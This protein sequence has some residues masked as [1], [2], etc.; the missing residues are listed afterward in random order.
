MIDTS[1]LAVTYAGATEPALRCPALTIDEGE[2][3]LLAG[4]TGSGKST[5]LRTLNGLVPHFS[6][7]TLAGR[8]IVAGRDTRTHRPRDLAEVVGFVGQDPQAGFVTETVEEEIAFGMETLGVGEQAMRRRVEE[9]LDVL[10]LAPLRTRPLR[11]LSGGQQQRVSVAAVLAAGPRILVLDEPTSAL[12]PVSAEEVL[13]SL[14]RLVHDL[15][16]TVVLAEHRLERTVHHADRVIL[17]DDGVA[18]GLLSPGEA[19]SRASNVPPVVELGRHRGW[20]PLP[21]SVRDARRRA[22]GLRRDL[23]QPAARPRSAG[24]AAVTTRSLHVRRSGRTVL[25]ELD[26][27]VCAGAVTALMGRN[28]SGKSTLLGAICAMVRVTSGTIEAAGIRPDRCR[29]KDLIGLI[30]MVPQDAGSLLLADSVEGECRTAD[31][32]FGRPPGSCRRI[33]DRLAGLD[34]GRH[35]RDLSEGQRVLLAVA[36]I[37]TGDPA[38]LLLDEPTRGLD[39]GAKRRLAA[40]LRERTANGGSVLMA[41]HDVEMAAEVADDV[42]LIAD[43]DV[44]AEGAAREILCDSMAFAPQIAKVMH[45]RTFLTVDDVLRAAGGDATAPH[46][47]DPIPAHPAGEAPR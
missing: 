12:D 15:G 31:R 8:V 18:S 29:P 19:M 25:R 16:V 4:A 30:G 14:D 7:G 5:L 37:L 42:L 21:L 13:A 33:L 44:I 23:P 43:G 26:L 32:D 24:E 20:E 3:V 27:T 46:A 35:P 28:G 22:V 34:G 10:S 39:Y 41:T 38:V 11:E 2:L 1:D 6:G 17:V 47:G 40:L 9:V 36:V 45:P